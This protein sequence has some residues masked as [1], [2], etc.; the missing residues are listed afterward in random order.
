[1]RTP[2]LLSLVTQTLT[3]S[4]ADEVRATT[5]AGVDAVWD[6]LC[7]GWRY[8]AWVVG[9]ARM[10]S[11]SPDWP[12]VGAELHHSVGGWPALLDDRTRVTECV[13]RSRLAL[14][15]GLWPSGETEVRL[16]LEA[17]PGGGCAITMQEDVTA[18][19][20]GLVPR[21]ARAALFWAR[22]VEALRRL[23]YLAERGSE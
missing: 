20:A 14:R 19:P 13:P 2:S 22:N 4:P 18:G 17:T 8:P 10:R 6:V 23:R 1:V 9:T 15:A 7:D 21:Q 5:T 16:L 12:D 11:V 3:W